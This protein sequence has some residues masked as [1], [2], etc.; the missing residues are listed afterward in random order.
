ML[1]SEPFLRWAIEWSARV[2]PPRS[3]GIPTPQLQELTSEQLREAAT[4]WDDLGVKR[5]PPPC[6]IRWI[7]VGILDLEPIFDAAEQRPDWQFVGRPRPSARIL[8]RSATD[9]QNIVVPGGGS[10]PLGR[11]CCTQR[12]TAALIPYRPEAAFLLS[13]P[14]KTF[15]ALGAGVPILTSLWWRVG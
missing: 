9:A 13:I 2:R 14:N 10:T 8:W 1:I 12:S 5:G 15:D 6:H 11:V 4:W 7:L 3:R